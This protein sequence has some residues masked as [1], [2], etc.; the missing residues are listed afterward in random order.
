[1]VV[2]AT[3]TTTPVPTIISITFNTVQR[4]RVTMGPH[5]DKNATHCHCY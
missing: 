2:I 1:M 4:L 3:T 5:S